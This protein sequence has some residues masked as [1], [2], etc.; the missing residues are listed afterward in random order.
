MAIVTPNDW[1]S[2]A[3]RSLAATSRRS[4]FHFEHLIEKQID[5]ANKVLEAAQQEYETTTGPLVF[6][7]QQIHDSQNECDKARQGLWTTCTDADVL[8]KL[9][10]VQS[11]LSQVRKE[12]HELRSRIDNLRDQATGDRA[13]AECQKQIVGGDQQVKTCLARAHEH[14]R[15]AAEYKSMLTKADRIISDL[16]HEES[17]IREQMLAP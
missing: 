1:Q 15:K 6:R 3:K 7:I 12:A 11:Q 16:E 17:V 4:S 13:E 2:E 10:D 14:D 8:D 9:A 5:V